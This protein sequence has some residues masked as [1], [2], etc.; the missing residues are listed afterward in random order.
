MKKCANTAIER[1][2]R[3]AA[4]VPGPIFA[5]GIVKRVATTRISLFGSQNQVPERGIV[6]T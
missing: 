2:A 4:I 3:A 1:A 5:V 6:R